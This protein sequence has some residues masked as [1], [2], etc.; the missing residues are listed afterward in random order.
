M[1][2]EGGFVNSPLAAYR[3]ENTNQTKL[4]N[5]NTGQATALQTDTVQLSQESLKQFDSQ[6]TPTA[7]S[8][9]IPPNEPLTGKP[10]SGGGNGGG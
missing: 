7:T 8:D 6:P 2:I 9:A 5:E 4:S 1:R 10:G 3:S